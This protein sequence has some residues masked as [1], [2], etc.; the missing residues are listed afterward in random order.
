MT[1]LGDFPKV[2]RPVKAKLT[3]FFRSCLNFSSAFFKNISVL[4]LFFHGAVWPV[5]VGDGHQLMSAE[6]VKKRYQKLLNEETH[7][8]FSIIF[9]FSQIS[10]L[11]G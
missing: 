9:L 7:G 4:F 10:V 2:F 3:I 1:T 6:V 11:I 5:G 8:L